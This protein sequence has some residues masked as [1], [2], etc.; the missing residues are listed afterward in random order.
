MIP[1]FISRLFSLNYDYDDVIEEQRAQRLLYIVGM[2]LI[3]AGILGAV[4]CLSTTFTVDYMKAMK[5]AENK[6]KGGAQS[7]QMETSHPLGAVL[8][9]Q[10]PG[11]IDKDFNEATKDMADGMNKMGEEM[12]NQ[13]ESQM[14]KMFTTEPTMFLWLSLL[15]YLATVVMGFVTKMA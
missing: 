15:R 7:M 5:N 8:M 11:D 10:N 12:G 3:V 2:M 6:K 1:S 4:T 14:E 13:L 9:L